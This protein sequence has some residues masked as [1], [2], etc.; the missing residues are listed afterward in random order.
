MLLT[1]SAFPR[2]CILLVACSLF[3][4]TLTVGC[5]SKGVCPADFQSHIEI[6]ADDAL[7]GRG[8]GTPGIDV[9]AGY[10]ASQFVSMGIEPG[11]DDGNSYFQEFEVATGGELVDGYSFNLSG[12]EAKPEREKDYIPFGFSSNDAFEGEVVFAGYGIINED[13]EYDDYKDLDVEGKVVLIL[14]R[15]PPGWADSG[16]PTRHSSFQA[17]TYTAKEQGAVALLIVNRVA[18]EAEDHLMRFGRGGK[19]SFGL[20]V[21]HIKQDLAGKMLSA[22]GLGSLTELQATLDDGGHASAPLAGVRLA[23]QAGVEMK[24]ARVRNVIGLIRGEGPLADEYVVIGAHYDHLGVTIPRHI[25]SRS[26]LPSEAQT[27]SSKSPDPNEAQIHNGADDNAS[28]TAGVIE[29]GRMLVRSKPL[30]RSVLLMAFTGEES[31]LLG[32]KHYADH[33][34]VPLEDIVAMLNMDMIGRFNDKKN[35]IQIFGTGAADEFDEMITRVTK[36]SGM[37]LRGDKSAIGPSDH[38]SFYRKEIP[39]LHIFTGLHNDYHQPSDDVDKINAVAGAHVTDLVVAL[40]EEIINTDKRPTYHKVA[41]RA[42]VFQADTGRPKA[43]MGIFPG[44]TAETSTSG[45][46]VDGVSDGGPAQK[47]GIRDGDI[48]IRIGKAKVTGIYDYMGSLRNAKPGDV[49]EV[50][51]KRKDKEV[52]VQLTLG[53]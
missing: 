26:P 16:R 4:A 2:R 41:A 44:Y 27:G 24:M 49:V 38:T 6:L 39:S 34:T 3:A 30:K 17:K 22:G 19:S 7:T 46:L 50:V 47:A 36:A 5:A 42:N 21:F 25:F 35:T 48:I 18:D 32:S 31:G 11:G 15:E 45:L 53:G 10:I 23:G 8:I 51:V 13:K 9:A 20:P 52:V 12:V 1:G 28:G 14:R 37:K 33:P 43:R 29:A 40:A